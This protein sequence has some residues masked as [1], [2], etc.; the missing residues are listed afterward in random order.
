MLEKN[1]SSLSRVE[2]K[3]IM[4]YK[5]AKGKDQMDLLEIM[6]YNSEK[7]CHPSTLKKKSPK[8]H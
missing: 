4:K 5:A 2:N 3:R 8:Q 1:R 6:L 7:T